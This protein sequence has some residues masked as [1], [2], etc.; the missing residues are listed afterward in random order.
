VRAA[1]LPDVPDVDLAPLFAEADLASLLSAHSALSTLRC[2]ACGGACSWGAEPDDRAR[3]TAAEYG[4]WHGPGIWAADDSSGERAVYGCATS[5]PHPRCSARLA[6]AL[7]VRASSPSAPACLPLLDHEG[8]CRFTELA[9]AELVP[10]EAFL[11]HHR[12]RDLRATPGRVVGGLARACLAAFLSFLPAIGFLLIFAR[13]GGLRG[14]YPSGLWGPSCAL[15]VLAALYASSL[16][17]RLRQRA[18]HR[19]ALSR[20]ATEDAGAIV[21]ARGDVASGYR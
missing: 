7:C 14:P 4:F 10:L 15:A 21:L 11:Q 19:G 8:R 20:Q 13:Q 18:A 2:P 12:A 17:A 3:A 16:P 6:L 1:K 5:C 9:S